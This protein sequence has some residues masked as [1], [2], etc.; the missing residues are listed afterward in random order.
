MV[1][2]VASVV[3]AGVAAV[4]K[5]GTLNT[6]NRNAY[7]KEERRAQE[8]QAKKIADQKKT[9]Q[10]QVANALDLADDGLSEVKSKLDMV[11]NILSEDIVIDNTIFKAND[12]SEIKKYINSIK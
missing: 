11:Y 12:M 4:L 6:E 1:K 5:N 9:E 8:E 7:L 10:N 2:N 3:T